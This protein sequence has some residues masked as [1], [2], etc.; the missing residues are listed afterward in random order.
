MVLV[1]ECNT[2][3]VDPRCH[4]FRM[5]SIHGGFSYYWGYRGRFTVVAA[6]APTPLWTVIAI[7]RVASEITPP[8]EAAA[9]GPPKVLFYSTIGKSA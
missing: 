9:T 1:C 7:L 6:Q 2:V 3:A 5:M 8:P 4:T